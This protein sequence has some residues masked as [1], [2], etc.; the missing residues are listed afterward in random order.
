MNP[1]KASLLLALPALLMLGGCSQWYFNMG[2]PVTKVELPRAEDRV[3]LA[4]VLDLLGP[5][6]RISAAQSGYMMAWEHWHVRENSFGISLGALGADFMSV[7]SGNMYIKG[8]FLLMTFDREHRLSSV[9]RSEWD[10]H[11]GGGQ[12]VQPFFGFVDVVEVGDLVG[13]L[14]QHRWGMST[15]QRLPRAL[16]DQSSPDSGD[17]GL[18]QRG[19]PDDLGQRSLEMR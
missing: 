17:A 10:T 13:P 15:L 19:T 1:R 7:D 2:S 3:P 5:P 16:N 9:T 14:P 6:Q 12:A 4:E 8:E 11:G 18:E